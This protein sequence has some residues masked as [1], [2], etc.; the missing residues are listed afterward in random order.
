MY[1]GLL[2]RPDTDRL[3]VLDIAYGIGL[4]ILQSDHRN[5]KIDLRLFCELLILRHDICKEL[6]VDLQLVPSLLEGNA[7]HILAL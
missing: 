4:R 6:I 3:S 1:P 2:P 7:E 5:G